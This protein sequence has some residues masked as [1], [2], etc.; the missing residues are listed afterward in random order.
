MED[1]TPDGD[2]PALRRAPLSATSGGPGH[3]SAKEH[4]SDIAAVEDEGDEPLPEAS[5]D[6]RRAYEVLE[7]RTPLE[8]FE[9]YV[10]ARIDTL[11]RLGDSER[12]AVTAEAL[13]LGR[14]AIAR[15]TGVGV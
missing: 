14:R 5:L 9:S 1:A 7:I 3:D 10:R 8:E 15:V 11:S 12:A 13:E 2:A 4:P 6:P